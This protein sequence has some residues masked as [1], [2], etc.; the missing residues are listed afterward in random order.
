MANRPIDY[1]Q[2][3]DNVDIMINTME[4][5]SMRSAGKTKVNA[6]QLNELYQL[7]ESV[8]KKIKPAKKEG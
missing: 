2:L 1:Q 3:L 6:A 7:R 4:Y 5:D 8:A